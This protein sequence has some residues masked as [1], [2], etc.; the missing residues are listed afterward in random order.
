[1]QKHFVRLS[2]SNATK[3]QGMT[4]EQLET[5]H[6]LSHTVEYDT[7]NENPDA[8]NDVIHCARVLE[9]VSN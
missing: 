6:S 8:L 3:M 1:M 2:K 5:A 4:A 7:N 9:M